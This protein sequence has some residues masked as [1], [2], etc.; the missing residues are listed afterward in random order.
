M[1]I[2]RIFYSASYIPYLFIDFYYVQSSLLLILSLIEHVFYYFVIKLFSL[3]L[4]LIIQM[5]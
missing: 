5:E 1:I 3:T 4:F 2:G